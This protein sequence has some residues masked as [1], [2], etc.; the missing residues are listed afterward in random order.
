[1]LGIDTIFSDRF[2]QSLGWSIIHS[3]W[4]GVLIGI[5]L[6]F[7]LLL[8]RRSSKMRYL[9]SVMA[10]CTIAGL[11]VI[12]F[13]REYVRETGPAPGQILAGETMVGNR[14]SSEN[15]TFFSSFIPFYSAEL[16][17]S[18]FRPAREF[19]NNNLQ[20]VVSLWL[21]GILILT[22]RFIGGISWLHRLKHQGLSPPHPT[23]R[24]RIKQM[25]TTLQ[26]SRPIILMESAFARVPLVMGYFKPI[27]LL[28]LGTVTGLPQDQVEAVLTHELAHI[29]RHDYLVNLVQSLAEV[30]FF[31]NPA[32]WWISSVIR[33]ERE[34]CCDDLAVA[35]CRNPLI[36]AS[37]LTNLQQIRL[38][39]PGTALAVTGGKNYLLRR[40]KRMIRQPKSLPP[41]FERMTAAAALII[42]LT[43]V[44]L[45]A[46]ISLQNKVEE[47]KNS[48]MNQSSVFVSLADEDTD[49]N[50][51][52]SEAVD[53]Y[54]QESDN[55]V[56]ATDSN[57]TISYSF[58]RIDG[59]KKTNVKVVLENDDILELYIDGRKIPRSEYNKHPD[60]LKDVKKYRQELVLHEK[61]L[62]HHHKELEQK[63]KA[64]QKQARKIAE[65]HAEIETQHEAE[66]KQREKE[67]EKRAQELAEKHAEIETGHEAKLKQREKE[68]QKRA[69]EMAEKHVE[70]EAQLEVELKQREKELEKQAQEM[71]EKH[72]EIETRHE[73]ELKQREKE[74]E[75]R[76]QEM[77]EKHAEF[78]VQH[79]A[80]LKQRE[81]ELE[82]R[83]QKLKEK[84]R[85]LQE[86]KIQHRKQEE[87]IAVI[88][89]ELIQD[90]L[91]GKGEAFSLELTANGLIINGVKQPKD[92]FQKYRKI[93]KSFGGKLDGN[94]G[95]FINKH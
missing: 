14:E 34:H 29:C 62:E 85:A 55:D 92:V 16:A 66:L 7:G 6:G 60:I 33:K 5:L 94:K 89:N 67:L 83:A 24:R 45:Y 68:L 88:K 10:L 28:P 71:A 57:R 15:T 84:K 25:C 8:L 42:C 86:K 77:A 1:M 40:I 54:A 75:K 49:D 39:A 78:E 76:A 46:G 70:F 48:T 56:E 93:F 72:A 11:A 17:G 23:W 4:Q 73:A 59:N 74:L 35:V 9:V 80:E 32:V 47:N 43:V 20:V 38:Q 31:Y 81:K 65:K 63:E 2:I 53:V 51:A 36:F 69:Q 61:E 90:K 3:L 27:I 95:L 12:A 30:L 19:C 26:I 13:Y 87:Q 64:L 18:I 21:T 22:V 50:I 44:T 52:V 58:N 41:I 91:V 79:E 82:K 37:A